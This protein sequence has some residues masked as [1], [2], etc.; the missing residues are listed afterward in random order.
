LDIPTSAQTTSAVET[1]YSALS[2]QY[3]LELCAQLGCLYSQDLVHGRFKRKSLFEYQDLTLSSSPEEAFLG[4]LVGIALF[5]GEDL[6]SSESHLFATVDTNATPQPLTTK[7]EYPHNGVYLPWKQ[8]YKN[9]LVFKETYGHCDVAV[10][11]EHN[12]KL[13]AWVV[14]ITVDGA[15]I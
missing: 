12:P 1:T 10:K 14:R 2:Q 3:L 4:N 15:M 11:F 6:E 9:L 8:S 13:G 7:T 5:S